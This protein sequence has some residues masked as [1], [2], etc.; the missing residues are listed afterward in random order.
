MSR[1]RP[2]GRRLRRRAGVLAAALLVP[3]ACSTGGS[4]TSAGRD[5]T[6]TVVVLAPASMTE[7]FGELAG[8]LR[9]EQG[10]AVTLSFGP[11]GA[12]ARQ[13]ASGAPADVLA[14]ADRDT[15]RLARGEVGPPQ[16][17]A[18][19]RLAIVVR[20]GNPSG[21]HRLGDLGRAGLIVALAAPGVPA[22]R[23][24]AAAF[25][26][27]EVPVPPASEEVDVK[28]VV[29][30][31]ALGEADAGVVYATDIEAGG[32]RVAGIA[33]PPAENVLAEYP[34]A[35]V[36]HAA[37]PAAA[38]RFVAALLSPE[39]QRLLARHRFVPA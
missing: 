21:I 19:N 20:S 17:F 23:Y 9:R 15:M 32:S 35:A 24:A 2:G 14:T 37:H 11:S 25:A 18:R 34:V 38:R 7:A 5:R 28:A 29:G 27:A 10:L 1:A 12:L 26:R 3:A 39:G 6:A 8:V 22:G 33:I 4:G 13:V 36:R 16:V 31:V 30:K